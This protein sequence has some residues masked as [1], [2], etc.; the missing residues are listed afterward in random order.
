MNYIALSPEAAA[1]HDA[2][3]YPVEGNKGVPDISIPLYTVRYGK[4]AIPI[5]L[6]YS[7]SS[8]KVDGSTAPNV[9]FGWVLDVGGSINRMIK[10]KPDEASEWYQADADTHFDQL[11]DSDDQYTLSS[12]YGWYGAHT[13]DTEK[14]EFTMSSPSGAA[15]FYLTE[16]RGRTTATFRRL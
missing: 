10:G 4:I 3:N 1:L 6:R 14:D 15:S 8:A 13:Y 11:R 9:G 7:T 2:V 5:V 16:R 12:I